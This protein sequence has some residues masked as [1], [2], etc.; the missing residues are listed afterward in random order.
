M[1]TLKSLLISPL[2]LTLSLREGRVREK[3][4]MKKYNLEDS[5]PWKS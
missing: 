5:L 1:L 4:R 2:T 3:A